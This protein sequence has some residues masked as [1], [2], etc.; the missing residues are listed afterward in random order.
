[1]LD[2]FVTKKKVERLLQDLEG[3]R[4]GLNTFVNKEVDMVLRKH[5]PE[6]EYE[7]VVQTHKDKIRDDIYMTS[8]LT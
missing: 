5:F 3:Q 8:K 4:E 1:M 7:F 2:L 6:E